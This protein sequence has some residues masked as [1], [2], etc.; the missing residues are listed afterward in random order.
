MGADSNTKVQKMHPDDVLKFVRKH[1]DPVV[2]AREVSDEFDV[3]PKAARYRLKQLEEKNK[4]VGKKIGAAATA[5]YP[6]Y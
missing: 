6:L 5:W 3:T 1:E 2:T 4:V